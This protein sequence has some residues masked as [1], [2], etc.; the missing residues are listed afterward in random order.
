MIT[1]ISLPTVITSTVRYISNCN[2]AVSMFIIGTILADVNN[3]TIFNKDTV[4]FSVFRLFI[5]PLIAFGI[6]SLIGLEKTAL[7]ISVLMTGMPAGATAAIF[8][9]RY[10]SDA[11]FATK[12]VVLTTLISMFTLPIWSYFIS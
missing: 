4:I 12:C 10:G 1:Q 9:S 3:T 7:G 2:S 11:P 8:A 5:L 6:G